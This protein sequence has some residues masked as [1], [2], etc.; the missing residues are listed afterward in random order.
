M[1]QYP[2]TLTMNLVAFP[3]GWKGR[4]KEGARKGHGRGTEV[5]KEGAQKRYGRGKDR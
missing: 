5:G 3:Q 4:G 2:P 1:D